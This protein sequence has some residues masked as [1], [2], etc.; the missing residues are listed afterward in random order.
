MFVFLAITIQMGHS[1]WDQMTD[2]RA[3]TDQFYTPSYSNMIKE[4]HPSV[5]AFHGQ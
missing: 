3:K 4:T 2:Y 1:L 5:S